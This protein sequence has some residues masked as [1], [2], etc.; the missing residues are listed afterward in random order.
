MCGCPTHSP[1]TCFR[2]RVH[3]SPGAHA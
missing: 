2:R 1:R 3:V